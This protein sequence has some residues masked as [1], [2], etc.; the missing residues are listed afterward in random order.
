MIIDPSV[1]YEWM[2]ISHFYRP[3]YV[4]QYATGLI[5]ALSIVSDIIAHKENAKENYIDFL[6]TGSRKDVLDILKDVNVDLNTFDPFEKAFHF[7]EQK[8]SELEL[9]KEGEENE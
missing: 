5:S 2:Y 8:V 6:K 7:I 4:Y 1:R 3:F 9:L